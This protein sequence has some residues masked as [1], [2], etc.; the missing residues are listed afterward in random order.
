MVTTSLR[1]PAGLSS[2]MQKAWRIIVGDLQR[3][4]T[5]DPSDAQL[6][7]MAA[8]MLG[9]A[10]EARAELA[11]QATDHRK[12]KRDLSH[13]MSETVRGTTS[14]VLLTVERESVKEFRLLVDLL[15]RR[16]QARGTG[17][18][19]RPKSL[20]EMRRGLKVAGG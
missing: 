12:G 5:L 16:A 7:E 20:S 11:G 8:M 10:R 13:L 3:L 4:G 18:G 9:R 6:I 1:M 19:K 14:N 15:E 17:A 2:E